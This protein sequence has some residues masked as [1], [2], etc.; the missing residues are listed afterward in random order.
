MRLN[1]VGKP[2]SLNGLLWLTTPE[3]SPIARLRSS[4][5][6]MQIPTARRLSKAAALEKQNYQRPW[7]QGREWLEPGSSKKAIFILCR[8]DS[9]EHRSSYSCNVS[10]STTRS[11]VY[12]YHSYTLDRRS[13]A[14]KVRASGHSYG[15]GTSCLYDLES[16]PPFRS[17]GSDLAQSCLL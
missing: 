5:S 10:G 15:P 9:H 2:R 16:H 13:A 17:A 11:V 4:A 1:K 14:G 12:Q 6:D 7:R 3:I 8:G